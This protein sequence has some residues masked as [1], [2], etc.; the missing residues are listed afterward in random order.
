MSEYALMHKDLMI[1]RFVIENNE[2]TEWVLPKDKRLLM[3]LP[4]PLKRVVHFLNGGYIQQESTKT[5]SIN[6]EGTW[7][8]E[9]WLRDRAIPKY[10]DNLHKYTKKNTFQFL[11]TNNSLSLT[12][13]YWTRLTGNKLSWNQIK[14]FKSN[15]IESLG[16]VLNNLSIYGS[17]GTVNAALGGQLEK[18]WYYTK[19]DK[20]A[21]VT[22]LYKRVAP[23]NNMLAIREVIASKI[24]ERLGYRN[25]CKYSYARDSKGLVV[26]CKCNAFTF[27]NLELITAYDLLEEYGRTQSDTI[28]DD[29]VGLAGNYG[30]NKAAV[31]TQLDIQTLVDY[32]ITNRDRHQNNIGFLRNS[33]T[34]EIV[35][36]APIFDSGSC[37][38]LEDQAPLGVTNTSVHNLYNTEMECLQHVSNINILDLSK[39]PEKRW[40]KNQLMEMY[41]A[42]EYSIQKYLSLY[43]D[44]I[45]YIRKLQT[46]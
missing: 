30:A 40:I 31:R 27:E 13:C 1:S 5:I 2:V 46:N 11:I 21:K 26:G 24:Y 29:I 42:N 43:L 10:R 38:A 36:I 3:H 22:K 9:S 15:K 25:F 44:K 33:D 20:D 32:L 37:A 6:E 8:L 18:F 34:L 7:L 23:E 4:L 41:N 39:L 45:D 17:Y 12:D 14:L 16:T 35:S 28:Y 19:T